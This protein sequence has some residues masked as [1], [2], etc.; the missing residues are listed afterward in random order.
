MSL[1]AQLWFFSFNKSVANGYRSQLPEFHLCTSITDLSTL[2]FDSIVWSRQTAVTCTYIHTVP[3]CFANVAIYVRT[4]VCKCRRFTYVYV[5]LH[6]V[7]YSSTLTIIVIH[8]TAALPLQLCSSCFRF[9]C[10]SPT[11]VQ[12][13]GGRAPS[14]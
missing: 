5:L 7:Y 8:Y 12:P 13:P 6:T 10:V 14:V 4:C 1:S 2:Q 9:T 11:P 3:T